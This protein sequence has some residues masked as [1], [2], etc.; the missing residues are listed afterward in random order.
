[1]QLASVVGT[2]GNEFIF[3]GHQ[4]L[5]LAGEAFCKPS[6]NSTKRSP[7]DMRHG[8]VET[9]DAISGPKTTSQ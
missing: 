2:H 8:S 6:R 9:T 3:K 7:W 1:M 5:S 4:L